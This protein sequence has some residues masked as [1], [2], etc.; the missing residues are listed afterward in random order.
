[1]AGSIAYANLFAPADARCR[2]GLDA[3]FDESHFALFTLAL[4]ARIFPIPGV[5][6]ISRSARQVR[7]SP[8]RR[9]REVRNRQAEK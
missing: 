8:R 1:M 2:A 5:F 6:Q 7:E 3:N 9:F 4:R